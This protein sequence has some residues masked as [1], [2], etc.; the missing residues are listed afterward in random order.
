[1]AKSKYRINQEQR[2]LLHER[3]NKAAR[4]YDH[5]PVPKRVRAAEKVVEDFK[6][7][8]QEHQR[9]EW[10][11]VR[12][13]AIQVREVIA[14]GSPDEALEEVRKFEAEA[15]KKRPEEPAHCVC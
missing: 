12:L 10:E 13:R 5:L 14:F 3:T 11:R 2:E 15:A 9:A 7:I 1:M 6:K 4:V 8:R